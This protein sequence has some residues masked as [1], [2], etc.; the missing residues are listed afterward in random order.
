MRFL[1]SL[2]RCK[3]HENSSQ[4]EALKQVLNGFDLTLLGIGAII[5]A[6]IFVMTGE[7]AAN[8]AGPALIFSYIICG[9]ACL[10]AGLCYAEFA[11][12][13]P[14]SGSAYTYS[15]VAFGEIIAWTVGWCLCL[16]Y[17]VQDTFQ[18]YI[19]ILYF[20]LDYDRFFWS[21]RG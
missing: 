1:H 18:T 2:M 19:A 21:S 16:E 13:V 20:F 11:A 6:G 14:I 9:I 3:P 4:T 12:M 17:L 7:A 15:Y 10:L 5:G 8:Y